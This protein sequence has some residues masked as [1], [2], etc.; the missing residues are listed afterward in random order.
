MLDEV[1]AEGHQIKTVYSGF[2]GVMPLDEVLIRVDYFKK[3]WQ[4]I[5]EKAAKGL[6]VEETLQALSLDKKFAWIKEWKMYR[7]AGHD[8]IND[9]HEH[10]LRL[11]WNS[12]GSK[13]MN[14]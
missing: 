1:F 5:L 12:T 13:K 3:L 2:A 4:E 14:H 8:W 6:S 11:F 9:E 10:N 7:N